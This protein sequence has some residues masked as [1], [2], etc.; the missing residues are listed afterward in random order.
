M[1]RFDNN[2]LI[3]DVSHWNGVVDVDALALNGVAGLIAKCGDGHQMKGGD[4]YDVANYVDDT[5]AENCQKAY[6]ADLPFGAYFFFR[7]DV[8]Q[9]ST[10]DKDFQFRVLQYALKNK[11]VDF[12]ALDLEVS[13]GDTGSNIR[14][15]T[16]KF[17]GWMEDTYHK[18]VLLYTSIGFISSYIG[19]WPRVDA[20]NYDLWLAQWIWTQKA[21]TWESIKTIYPADTVKIKTPGFAT[22][23][24]WQWATLKGLDGI[25]GEVDVNF[26]NGSL[27]SFH[28]WANFTP[29]DTTPTDPP[30]IPGDEPEKPPVVVPGDNAV[31][32]ELQ[33]M[34]AKLSAILEAVKADRKI[35]ME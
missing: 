25:S 1:G 13:G 23:K 20:G 11:K 30:V 33:A 9:A 6:D 32:A 10:P 4:P 14:D 22:W 18:P 29:K 34:N 3:I 5:F 2:P 21:T 17:I 24:I 19:E 28:A 12:L 27:A 7:P 31:L 15:K 16:E 35:T 8:V 26:W